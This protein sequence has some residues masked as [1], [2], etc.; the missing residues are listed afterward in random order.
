[1]KPHSDPAPLSAALDEAFMARVHKASLFVAGLVTTMA[2]FYRIGGSW[3]L[4]FLGAALWSIANLWTLER[5][6][7]AAIRPGSRDKVAIG[8]G[9]F[10]KLPLL[11]ALVAFLIFKGGFAASALVAGVSVPLF[12]ILMKVT[13]RMLALR[14]RAGGSGVPQPRS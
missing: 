13:G 3:S 4:G 5:L 7:R 2:A 14:L 6:V 8:M 11:Y 12:V 9:L 10:F 1:M